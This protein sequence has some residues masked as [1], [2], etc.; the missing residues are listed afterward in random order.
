VIYLKVVDICIYVI[1]FIVHT[2]AQIERKVQ[3]LDSKT[4]IIFV[5][6]HLLHTFSIEIE[7]DSKMLIIL[8]HH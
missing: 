2:V 7:W 5:N 3:P 8:Q 4:E 1:V 6:C